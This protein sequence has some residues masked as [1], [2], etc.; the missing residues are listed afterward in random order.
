MKAFIFA[1]IALLPAAA[2]A[3]LYKTQDT[4][5]HY[6]TAETQC[7]KEGKGENWEDLRTCIA[8]KKGKHLITIEKTWEK[9]PSKPNK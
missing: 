7:I 9:E 1:I 6:R 2:M 4:Y 5:R 8:S 3:G